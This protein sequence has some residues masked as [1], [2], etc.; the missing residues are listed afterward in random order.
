[1]Q[2]G[3]VVTTVPDL[4]CVLDS[5]TLRPITTEMLTY[6]QRIRVLG[7]PA[8]SV[9]HTSKGLET[10]GPRYFGYDFDYIPFRRS[11]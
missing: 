3:V 5:E 4:I 7:M 6:G 9:W 11:L 10:V 8:E 2:N 1:M